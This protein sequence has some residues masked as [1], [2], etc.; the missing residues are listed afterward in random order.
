MSDVTLS[1]SI[2]GE[3]EGCITFECPYCGSEFKFMADEYHDE[4]MPVD[5]LFCPYCGLIKEP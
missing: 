3:S 4:D 2:Q 1:F 5:E